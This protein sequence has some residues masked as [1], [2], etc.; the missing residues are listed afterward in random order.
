MTVSLEDSPSRMSRFWAPRLSAEQAARTIDTV[1][2]ARD[3]SGSTPTTLAAKLAAGSDRAQAPA[4]PNV[5]G[6]ADAAATDERLVAEIGHELGNYFHK[7]YYWAEFLQEKRSDQSGDAAAVE[8]LGRTIEKLE[9]FLKRAL[10]CFRPVRLSPVK[11]PVPDAVAA[12]VV[13]LRAHLKGWP[14]RVGDAGVWSQRKLSWDPVRMQLVLEAIAS[15]LTEQAAAGSGVQVSLEGRG[16]GIEA[17]FR[18]EGGFGAPEFQSGVACLEWAL[19]ERIV[20]SHRGRLSERR[21]AEGST[22]LALYLPF[23]H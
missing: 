13:Q 3:S 20:R 8:M 18:I 7:L 9:G 1:M 6:D 23:D 4:G 11:A 16:N 17:E 22:A 10:E 2:R 12:M 19:A 5:W 21:S 14:V 15:R